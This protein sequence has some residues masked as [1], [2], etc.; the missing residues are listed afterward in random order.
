MAVTAPAI[1]SYQHF[2]AVKALLL[3]PLNQKVYEWGAVPGRKN[4]AGTTNPGTAPNIYV[5]LAVE[6][7]FAETFVAGRAQMSAWRIATV[8]V[9][10]TPGEVRWAQ[11]RV[12]TALESLR[13]VVAGKTT[14]PVAIE[15]PG[16][17]QPDEPSYSAR[18]T[19]TYA[20]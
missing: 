11:L 9:G 18:D 17:P 12:A 3:A 2:N 19:F 5:L 15:T 20:L 6:R 10:R 14:T 16:S 4:A 8:S 1:D 13:L 7:R